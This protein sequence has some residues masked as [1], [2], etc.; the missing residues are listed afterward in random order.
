MTKSKKSIAM[1]GT[2]LCP[3]VLG[4]CAFLRANGTTYRTSTVVAIH[5]QSADMIHFET[6]NSDYAVCGKHEI[7]QKICRSQRHPEEWRVTPLAVSTAEKRSV[8]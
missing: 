1:H 5:E 4:H 3:L 8:A 7:L 6:L 2:L